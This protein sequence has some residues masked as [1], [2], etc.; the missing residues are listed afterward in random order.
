MPVEQHVRP[1]RTLTVAFWAWKGVLLA[2]AAGSQVGPSYDTSSN[3]LAP[4]RDH[5]RAS[6]LGP[7][8]ATRLTSWDAIYFV[9]AAQRGYLFEQE[10]AFGYALPTCM[11]LLVR[12]ESPSPSSSL[13]PAE[14][15]TPLLQ[16]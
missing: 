2:I 13:P 14:T 12:G 4:H 15:G 11:A 3:L 9:R 6:L 10:W 16:P 1:Y 5:Q 7:G 8:L